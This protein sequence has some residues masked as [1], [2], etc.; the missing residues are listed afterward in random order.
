M[1]RVSTSTIRAVLLGVVVLLLAGC[2]MDLVAPIELRADGSAIAGLEA[3]FDPRMLAELDALGVDPTA[4]LAAVAAGDA[5]WE[6]TRTRA[7]DGGLTVALRREVADAAALPDVYAQL[8][9][10]LAPEDPALELDLDRA[11]VVDRRGRLAGTASFRAPVTSGLT[12]DGEEFGAAGDELAALVEEAVTV[13]IEVVL[14]GPVEDHDG[15]LLERDTV[16]FDVTTDEPRAFRVASAPPPWW[17]RIPTD[18][19]TWLVVGGAVVVVL[20]LA[21]LLLS[22]RR[23]T[24]ASGDR[25]T[26]ASGDRATPE[27]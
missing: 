17:S 8:T 24:P 16:R 27:A 3:R 6:L 18:A 21:L 2:R 25:A 4:E 11:E 19:T 12:V 10:G 7:E 23:A 14:P 13:G 20:G 5:D 26:P 22:R 1:L 9:A 15:F